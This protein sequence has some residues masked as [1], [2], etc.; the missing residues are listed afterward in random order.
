MADLPHQSAQFLLG[1]FEMGNVVHLD[2]NRIIRLPR[3]AAHQMP[4]W[5]DH[6]VV[7]AWHSE[8]GTLLFQDADD[9]H[10]LTPQFDGFADAATRSRNRFVATFV[11]STHT[12]RPASDSMLL[13]N[14]PSASVKAAESP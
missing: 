10:R 3:V 14:L 13:M 11:P 4:H 5:N 1:V 2:L 7:Q 8:E 12:G 9:F 6:L